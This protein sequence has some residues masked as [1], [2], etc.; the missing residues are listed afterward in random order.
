MRRAG[1]P[2]VARGAIGRSELFTGL[3]ALGFANGFTLSISEALQKAP[4]SST[5][6][7]T[8]GISAVV[9]LACIVG[10]VYSVRESSRPATR[11]DFAVAAVAILAFLPP[12]PY[13]SWLTIGAI[14]LYV[15]HTS[16]AGSFAR[17][18][19]AILL[20]VT[21]PMFWSRATFSMLS[22]T[23]LHFDATLVANLVGTTHSGNA[24]AFP[25]G[26]GYL[27]IA[28]ACS[29]LGNVSLALLCYVVFA[30]TLPKPLPPRTFAFCILACAAVIAINVLR[31][32]CSRCFR[33][34]STYSRPHRTD[35]R[36]LAHACRDGRH[37]LVWSAS[38]CARSG[39]KVLF[40]TV[41]IA[42]VSLK[43]VAATSLPP[44][45]ASEAGAV[46]TRLLERNGFTVGANDKDVD[47]FTIA[48]H[49]PHCDLRLAVVSPHGWH[50]NLIRQLVAP[51][52]KLV[53]VFDGETFDEQ[54][55]WRTWAS[56]YLSRMKT[57]LGLHA[58][59]KPVL[60]VVSDPSCAIGSL[61]WSEVATVD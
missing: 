48:A 38:C 17:R 3:F 35:R 52:E 44:P 40:G 11:F 16:A 21:V 42:S 47:L 34:I 28:P 50:R 55:V 36:Q 45:P 43:V 1:A 31:L 49:G 51:Q 22:D 58:A 60:A 53:Y 39:P 24:I 4:L 27:W 41:L 56:F 29:S 59:T 18:G 10:L 9:W 33:T 23:L 19:A 37:H 2:A 54:P 30:K 61:P 32:A 25:D 6:L 14:A 46:V 5:L 15:I 26:S 8:F 7:N 20:A 12:V 13:L 57:F